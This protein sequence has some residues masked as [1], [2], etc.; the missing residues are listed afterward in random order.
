MD[1]LTSKQVII[2]NVN[3][4]FESYQNEIGKVNS[5]SNIIQ[6]KLNQTLN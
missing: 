2:D 1:I 5:E 3:N 6:E 4:I